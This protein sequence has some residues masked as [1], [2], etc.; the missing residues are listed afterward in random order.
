VRDIDPD[1]APNGFITG[2][3][4]TGK[5]LVEKSITDI[6][7]E[8]A[9]AAGTGAVVLILAAL[10]VSGVIGFMVATR[11]REIAVRMALGASRWRVA[12]LMLRDVVRLVVPGVAMGLLGSA[13]LVRGF[14]ST[15]LGVVEPVVYLVAAMIAVG[16]ALVAGLPAARRA[17]SVQPMVAMR[18]D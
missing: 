16:V 17:A 14:L 7:G 9:A 1:F 13:V 8:S 4:V 18:S 11:K 12:V 6:I 5:R 15:P 2:G 10:G 3:F